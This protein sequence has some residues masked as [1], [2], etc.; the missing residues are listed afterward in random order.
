MSGASGQLGAA[1]V[2]ENGF[3]IVTGDVERLAGRSP[4]P[5]CDVL[6]ETMGAGVQS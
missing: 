6:S 4:G 1:T 5:L 3:D 2:T